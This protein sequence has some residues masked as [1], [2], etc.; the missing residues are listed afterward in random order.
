LSDSNTGYGGGGSGG[1][2][3]PYPSGSSYNGFVNPVY[4]G[5]SVT[6]SGPTSTGSSAPY[7]G[8]ARTS[9]GGGGGAGNAYVGGGSGGSGIVV[10]KW[11]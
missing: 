9:S 8:N 4:G 11:T 5:G 10:L 6:P 7:L 2:V 3:I 1:G